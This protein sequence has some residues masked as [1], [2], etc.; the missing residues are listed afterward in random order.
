MQSRKVTKAEKKVLNRSM[1]SIARIVGWSFFGA[2]MIGV[3]IFFAVALYYLF[4]NDHMHHHNMIEAAAVFLP[5]SIVMGFV[6]YIILYAL[7]YKKRKLLLEGTIKNGTGIINRIIWPSAARYGGSTVLFFDLQL[8]SGQKEQG[9]LRVHSAKKGDYELDQE[10]ILW[11]DEK[12]KTF[13]PE[14]A[15]KWYDPG[16]VG[17]GTPYE[18]HLDTGETTERQKSKNK[19]WKRYLK[20]AF[21]ILIVLGSLGNYLDSSNS[22]DDWNEYAKLIRPIMVEQDAIINDLN[23][24]NLEN[25]LDDLVRTAEQLDDELNA[26][27]PDNSDIEKMHKIMIKR[28]DLIVEGFTK[29][30]ASEEKN[31]PELRTESSD[32]FKEADLLIE[33]F[34][35][36]RKKFEKKHH[37]IIDDK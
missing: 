4:I 33:E 37:V 12:E 32:S 36:L 3:V 14:P 15:P 30:Q 23:N 31:D 22:A 35:K 2:G 13:F 28:A 21:I 11:F 18:R 7:S 8:P 25:K 1:S 29:Y 9:Y 27:K 26:I 10:I 5:I 6:P 24:L 20:W 34:I 17:G 16:V 19:S